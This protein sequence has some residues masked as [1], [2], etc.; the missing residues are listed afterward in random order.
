[1][2]TRKKVLPLLAVLFP[3]FRLPVEVIAQTIPKGAAIDAV[4]SKIM[5]HTD[6]EC[7]AVAVIDHGKVGTAELLPSRL[8]RAHKLS[9]LMLQNK[10]LLYDLLFRC[11]SATSLM[12]WLISSEERGTRI[13]H[14]WSGAMTAE[15]A[16]R[17]YFGLTD[18]PIQR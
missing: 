17:S 16:A 10:R 3:A 5:T 13:M 9:E 8:H 12:Q 18:R 2:R 7:M 15:P 14:T 11:V 4:V 6:G 1:M